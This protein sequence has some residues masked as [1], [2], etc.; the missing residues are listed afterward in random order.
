MDLDHCFAAELNQHYTAQLIGESARQLSNKGQL[1][2][3]Q[4]LLP[5][6]H[7]QGI[8]QTQTENLVPIEIPHQTILGRVIV[9]CGQV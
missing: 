3:D 6:T 7:S 4:T 5:E 9:S 1:L 2:P 8:N